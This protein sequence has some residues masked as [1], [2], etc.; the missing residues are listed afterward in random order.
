MEGVSSTRRALVR[1]VEAFA[2]ASNEGVEC[3][4]VLALYY[5]VVSVEPVPLIRLDPVAATLGVREH[6]PS[7]A[8]CC[9]LTA[10]T[11][12]ATANCV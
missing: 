11:R 6:L 3:P 2:G 7:P 8:G 1:S 12:S 4:P 10:T 5:E 9:D